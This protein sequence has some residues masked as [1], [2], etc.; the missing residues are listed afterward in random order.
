[1]S[2]FF[3]FS[4]LLYSVWRLSFIAT[5]WNLCHMC[6][7][8]RNIFEPTRRNPHFKW[9]DPTRAIVLHMHNFL[10]H[11]H[12]ST[13]ITALSWL[14]SYIRKSLYFKLHYSVLDPTLYPTQTD[15]WTYPINVQL[16]VIRK[17]NKVYC[18]AAEI[19]AAQ[20]KSTFA[21]EHANER[22]S[23]IFF[24]HISGPPIAIKI[25]ITECRTASK[26]QTFVRCVCQGR[27]S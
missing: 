2:S 3:K 25:L 11:V 27:P 26:T 1:M 6:H 15:P 21:N 18:T 16:Y 20:Y 22:H 4:R 8:G 9:P 10:K 13:K 12:A 14:F 17:G 23:D 7:M 24:G 5:R 19:H